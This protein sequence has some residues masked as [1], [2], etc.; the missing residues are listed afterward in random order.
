MN[1]ASIA[2]HALDHGIGNIPLWDYF[3]ELKTIKIPRYLYGV[4]FEARIALLLA[5]K[6]RQAQVIGTIN[7][8]RNF[9]EKR[10]QMDEFQDV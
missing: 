8:L 1:C 5:G 7:N 3:G 4:K 2:I 10:D 9:R 6:V